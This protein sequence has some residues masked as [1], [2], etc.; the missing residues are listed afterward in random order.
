LCFA[1]SQGLNGALETKVSQCYGASEAS[2]VSPEFKQQM[3]RQCG[4]YLN[5][6]RLVNTLFMIIP[7]AVLFL[8]ADVILITI[9]KQNALVSELAIQY[10]IICMPGVWAMT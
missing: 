10:C 3:R 1:I 7:T 2:S 6:A 5:I 8:F 9:F 4:I